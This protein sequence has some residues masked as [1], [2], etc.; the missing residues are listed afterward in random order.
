MTALLI[1][2]GLALLVLLVLACA[3]AAA[4]G[5]LQAEHAALEAKHTDLQTSYAKAHA[6]LIRETLARQNAE[7]ELADAYVSLGLVLND[8]R[9]TVWPAPMPR[10]VNLVVLPASTLAE[11]VGGAE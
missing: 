4:T 6:R 3:R 2:I 1:L 10:P 7:R 8:R 5:D 11:A 9:L